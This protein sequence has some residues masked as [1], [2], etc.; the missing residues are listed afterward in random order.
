MFKRG[1]VVR[2]GKGKVEYT[3]TLLTCSGAD[4]VEI[5]SHN[6]GKRQDVETSRLTLITAAPTA[7][8]GDQPV[9]KATEDAQTAQALEELGLSTHAPHIEHI[10]GESPAAYQRRTGRKLD[11]RTTIYGRMILVGLQMKSHIAGKT[12]G[13]VKARKAAKRAAKTLKGK[14]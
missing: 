3:V 6:T 10:P 4:M 1:D 14:A 11:G 8:E 7:E 13:K 5:E 12:E 9:D 2:I